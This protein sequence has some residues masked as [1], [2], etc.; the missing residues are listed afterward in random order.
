MPLN[1]YVLNVAQC[2][3]KIAQNMAKSLFHLNV[4]FVAIL[5]CGSVG[6]VPISAMIVIKDN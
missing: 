5:A 2:K 4:D 6:E 3:Q 1:L